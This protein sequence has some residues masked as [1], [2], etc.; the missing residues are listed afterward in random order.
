MT[1]RHFRLNQYNLT[2]RSQSTRRIRA[3]AAALAI[4]TIGP[5]TVGALVPARAAEVQ[6]FTYVGN[7]G[8]IAA[9]PIAEGLAGAV[10]KAAGLDPIEVDG[11][12]TFTPRTDRVTIEI[13]DATAL[14][15]RVFM[16]Y[17]TAKGWRGACVPVSKPTVLAGLAPGRPSEIEIWGPGNFNCGNHQAGAAGTARLTL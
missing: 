12:H 4:A 3:A 11:E 2:M 17:K 14:S 8:W 15:G 13:N 1:H 5:M 10:S 9:F 6:E 7:V 16:V